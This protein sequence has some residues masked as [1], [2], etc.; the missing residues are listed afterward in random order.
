MPQRPCGV[1]V[2][3]GVALLVAYH[4]IF[5]QYFP[6]T[7]GKLGHDYGLFLPKLLDG[8]F[9][10]SSNGLLA[11]P[12]FTPAFCGGI[13]LFPDPQSM[14]YSVPQFLTFVTDPLTSVYI[15][16]LLFATLGAIGFYLLLQRV[17]HTGP[18][19]AL[20]GAGLFVFNG[21]YAHRMIIGH[22]TYHPFMLIPLVAFFLLRSGPH[23]AANSA[24]AVLFHG[25]M[26][27]ILLA[28]MFQAGMVNVILPAIGSIIVIGL[29]YHLMGNT[30]VQFWRRVLC[31]AGI[32]TAL[33]SA[34][35]VAAIAYLQYFGR[36]MY[37]LPG[38]RT[39][40]E[41]VR[42][43]WQSLFIAPALDLGTAALVNVQW[44]LDRHEF[45]FGVTF[46]P[47][48][49]LL[50]GG[51]AWIYR[52][53]VYGIPPRYLPQQWLYLALMA[54]VLLLPIALNYYTPTWNVFLKHLPILRNSTSL[55]RWI[56]L[57]IPVVILLTALAGASLHHAR[58]Y[59]PLAVVTSLAIVVMIHS[60]TD[61]QFYHAQSYD[62]SQIRAAYYAVQRR[63]RFP[64]ITHIMMY[65]DPT[66][67]GIMP[68]GRNDVLTQGRSQLL[69][70]EPLF[71]YRLEKFPVKTLRPGPVSAI[72]EGYL[73]VKNPVCY[74]Y[75]LENACEP[76]DH[77]SVE[78]PEVVAAFIAY[79]PMPFRLPAWQQVANVVNILAI[80]GIGGFLLVSGSASCRRRWKSH[81]ER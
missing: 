11:L 76:G 50:G 36:D 4:L 29:V 39:L 42:I 49:W 70:Y 22:L 6:N 60:F 47:L 37:T 77:F 74:V 35:L 20:L 12:W 62:P 14:Y 54:S 52:L 38:T 26:G 53:C 72:H 3:A 71:G 25:V 66:G 79:K 55:V 31:A 51:I 18:W 43:A 19:L 41:S 1:I 9:W 80:A 27:G 68:P 61:R 44:G 63:E 32:A 48:V 10:F 8:Y 7:H 13:P 17:F 21:F 57:Y 2:L 67:R 46:I 30:P 45:E 81:R 15:T 34:K 40:L 69:C 73:N 75:P 24:R 23:E 28:Y 5:Q 33:C 65:A 59:L 58:P 56:S 64:V 16:F 78:Q